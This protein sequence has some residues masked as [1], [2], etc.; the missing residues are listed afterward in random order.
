MMIQ[1]QY[2]YT[3][4]YFSERNDIHSE[5]SSTS[6]GFFLAATTGMCQYLNVYSAKNKAYIDELHVSSPELS[7]LRP[8]SQ[9]LDLL[10]LAS[11]APLGS[12]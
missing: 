12:M 1:T 5:S 4:G 10:H 7:S 8:S 6:T 9:M 11:C 2:Y 3:V